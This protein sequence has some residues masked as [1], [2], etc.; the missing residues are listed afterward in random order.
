[1]EIIR[2]ENVSE[3]KSGS[4]YYELGGRFY[5]KC[6]NCGKPVEVDYHRTADDLRRDQDGEIQ[7][8]CGESCKDA[9]VADGGEIWE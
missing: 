7:Y 9:F 4:V 1:M 6:W 5:A 2:V 8:F 3:M